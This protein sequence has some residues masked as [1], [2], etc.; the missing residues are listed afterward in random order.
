MDFKIIFFDN[1]V[2]TV[3]KNKMLHIELF[4]NWA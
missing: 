4:Q 3:L 1:V 2:M